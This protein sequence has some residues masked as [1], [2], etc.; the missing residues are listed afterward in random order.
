[1]ITDLF[2]HKI[3]SSGDEW[4]DR[5]VEIAGFFSRYD[6]KPYDR[7]LIERELSQISPRSVFAARDRSKFR[8]E[9]SAYPAY[10]GLYWLENVG[11][12]WIVRISET[13]KKFLLIEEPDPGSFLR[14]QL[15]LFQ[16]PNGMGM[17]YNKRGGIRVQANSRDRTLRIASQGIHLSPI[18]LICKS[19]LADACSRGIDKYSASITYAELYTLANTPNINARC[20]PDLSKVIDSLTKI[21]ASETEKIQS[22]ERRFHI[23]KHTGLFTVGAG[24]IAFRIPLNESDRADLDVKIQTLSEIEAQFNGFDS[25]TSGRD[26]E[27]I[28]TRGEWGRYFDSLQVLSACDIQNL[29]FDPAFKAGIGEMTINEPVEELRRAYELMEREAHS[30]V[31]QVST[32]Q[33]EFADPEVTRIKRQRRSLAHKQILDQLDQLLRE[34][35]GAVPKDSPHI[36]LYADIPDDGSYLFEV[37]S[38]GENFLDQIR[39]GISQLYEYRFRY[40]ESVRNASVLCLVVNKPISEG[41]WL[42]DYVCSDRGICLCWFGEDGL[43]HYPELCA[44]S[45]VGLNA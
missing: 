4:P 6:G 26:L 20:N 24:H 7:E 29:A 19:L 18:R 17:S 3:H 38:G 5:L 33:Q 43:L 40:H 23:L 36:D 39:K 15:T 42:L 32:R 45:M 21:R 27:N 2:S 13:T 41:S 22:F 34:K 12:G 9:I 8:D 11:N 16:Y 10:L 30:P 25:I 28:V 37:K 31:P 14:M 35:L 1:M 44:P